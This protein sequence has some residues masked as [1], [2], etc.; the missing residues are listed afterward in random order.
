[1]MWSAWDSLADYGP[2]FT[3]IAAGGSVRPCMFGVFARVRPD[4]PARSCCCGYSAG[5]WWGG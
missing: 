4:G 5:G 1:M 2:L 3:P